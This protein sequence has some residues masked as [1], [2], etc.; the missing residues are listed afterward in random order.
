MRSPRSAAPLAENPAGLTRTELRELFSRN[1]SRAEIGRALDLLAAAAGLARC[2]TERDRGR[3][4]ERWRTIQP[5]T[6]RART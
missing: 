1:R 6:A 5:V 4:V 3:P 2:H